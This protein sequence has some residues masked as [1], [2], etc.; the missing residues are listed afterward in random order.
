MTYGCSE[1]TYEEVEILNDWETVTHSHV[2]N[3]FNKLDPEAV[4]YCSIA[5]DEVWEKEDGFNDYELNTYLITDVYSDVS[6][7]WSHDGDYMHVK[8]Y[9]DY[10]VYLRINAFTF[11]NKEFQVEVNSFRMKKYYNQ[12]TKEL[13]ALNFE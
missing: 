10:T 13:I 6:F 5:E 7:K 1:Q 2:E 3:Y 4:K 12:E 8:L 11:T 9:C